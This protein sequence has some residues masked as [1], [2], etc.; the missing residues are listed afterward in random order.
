MKSSY[1]LDTDMYI[2]LKILLSHVYTACANG[3]F[4]SALPQGKH[5]T[6]ANVDSEFHLYGQSKTQ[7]TV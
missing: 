2:K 1:H 7:S 6:D 3:E 4:R 5:T